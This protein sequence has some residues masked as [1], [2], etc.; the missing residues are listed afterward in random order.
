MRG[1]VGGMGRTL[2]TVGSMGGVGPINFGVGQKKWHRS[3]FWRESKNFRG[4]K[5]KKKKKNGVSRN[6]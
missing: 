3:K 5:K 6:F 1:F 4:L 2:A